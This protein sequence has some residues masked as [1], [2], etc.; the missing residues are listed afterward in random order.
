MRYLGKWYAWVTS[1]IALR[2]FFFFF[3]I[4]VICLQ[5]TMLRIIYLHDCVCRH[6]CASSDASRIF[7]PSLHTNSHDQALSKASGTA[8]LEVGVPSGSSP[9]L[10][11]HFSHMT[12]MQIESFLLPQTLDI[13]PPFKVVFARL[14]EEWQSDIPTSTGSTNLSQWRRVP[15]ASVRSRPAAFGERAVECSRH[16]WP[17]L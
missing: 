13:T 4:S 15:L 14:D 7:T 12:L 9:R 8:M 1:A 6:S 11:L 3:F 5:P 10:Y 16:A 17:R 2:L